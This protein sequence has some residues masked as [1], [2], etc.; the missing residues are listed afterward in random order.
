M[1]ICRS[2][3]IS[4][5]LMNA[6]NCNSRAQFDPFCSSPAGRLKSVF[7]ASTMI[8][9]AAN[10]LSLN[11][12]IGVQDRLRRFVFG[13]PRFSLRALLIAAAAIPVVFYLMTL[14]APWI[15]RLLLGIWGL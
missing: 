2:V 13:I 10:W 15:G 4:L 7:R 12:G 9:Q 1:G 11:G 8:C 6:L 3:P 5:P 14:V